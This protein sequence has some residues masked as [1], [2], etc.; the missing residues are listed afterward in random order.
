MKSDEIRKKIKNIHKE[1]IE[2]GYL[3]KHS[4]FPEAVAISDKGRKEVFKFMEKNPLMYLLIQIS[5]IEASEIIRL[6]EEGTTSKGVSI[7]EYSGKAGGN[8]KS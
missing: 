5:V 6:K 3:I 8:Q 4:N 1:L 2:E 7:I